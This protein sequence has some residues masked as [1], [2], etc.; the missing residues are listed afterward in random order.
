MSLIDKSLGFWARKVL[1]LVLVG[2]IAVAVML[3]DVEWI[4]P[5]TVIGF[6]AVLVFESL[7]LKT[8]ARRFVQDTVGPLFKQEEAVEYSGMFWAGVGALIV[9][10]FAQPLAYSYGF[11]ILALADTAAAVTG[12]LVPTRRY[13]RNKSVSGA[14]GC[15]VT[16][17]LVTWFYLQWAGL[18]FPVL[19]SVILMGGLATILET[20]SHP[21]D[22]NFL[23]LVVSSFVMFAALSTL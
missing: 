4:K 6:I 21:F 13:Y 10:L 1:H 22:D 11:A 17:A 14:I 19:P 2:S 3:V 16:A 12:R 18:P 7:R 5:L 20:Y 15:F 8:Q 23:M 9:A